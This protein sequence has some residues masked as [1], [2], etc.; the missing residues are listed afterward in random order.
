MRAYFQ[1]NGKINIL[2]IKIHSSHGLTIIHINKKSF[3]YF[4]N[5]IIA[6][7]RGENQFKSKRMFI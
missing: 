1:I 6:G 2:Q 3:K 5:L 7:I 4:I